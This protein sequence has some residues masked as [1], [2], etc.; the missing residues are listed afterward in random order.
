LHRKALDTADFGTAK[1]KLK[2][3][4]KE[5]ESKA[6]EVPD[7]TFEDAGK[8]YVESLY[9]LKPSSKLRRETSL[10]VI[11]PSFK[12]RKL[13]TITKH[14]LTEWATM[15]AKE[16]SARTFTST[17][18]S[19]TPRSIGSRPKLIAFSFVRRNN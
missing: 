1:R 17:T 15:R 19:S 2:D 10:K 14:D 12:G 5:I 9:E 6:V 8:K 13:R 11:T 3:F 18:P 4:I 16:C 7:I